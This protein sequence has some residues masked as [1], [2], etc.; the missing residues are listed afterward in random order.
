MVLE[1]SC[2]YV[3]VNLVRA[4]LA[5]SKS[6]RITLALSWACSKDLSST[7]ASVDSNSSKRANKDLWDVAEDPTNRSILVKRSSVDVV[8]F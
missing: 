6:A 4:L 3:A 8:G 2:L 7:R 1:F 5:A